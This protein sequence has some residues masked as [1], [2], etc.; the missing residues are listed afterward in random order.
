VEAVPGLVEEK[1]SEG[2][3]VEVDGKYM[4]P[5]TMK[6][7]G[8]SVEFH[9]VPVPGGNFKMGSSEDDEYFVEDEGPQA[10]IEVGPMWVS[11]YEATWAEYKLYMSMYQ[12][13]KS[14][15]GQGL[16]A[17]D[18]S[19]K[20]DAVTAP[21]ELY[22]PTYTFEFGDDPAYPAVTMTQYAAKQYTKWLSKLTGQQYRLP[23]E[24]EW[25]YACRG[26]TTTPFSFGEDDAEIDDYAWYYDNSDEYPHP[27]GQKKPNPFGLYDMHGNVMEWV[28]DGYTEDGHARLA[29]QDQPVPLVEAIHWAESFDNR[30]MRGGS[31]QD[32][33]E[34]L[35]SAARLA[36]QDEDWKE[37]DPNIPLSPWWFTDDPTRGLGF[38]VFRSYKPLDDATITKFWDIDNEDL[39]FDVDMRVDEGRGV[40]TPIDPSLAEDIAGRN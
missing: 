6:I 28:I 40:I 5:Y 19:N 9:M 27:V 16:R 11:K 23:T 13:F 2:P 7:P 14:L 20:V 22:D 29:E 12:L 31:F 21:T 24:A 26:G 32:D 33:P 37:E 36:S 3:F 39:Q 10:E 1:P 18:E 38:R 30:V 25:E 8:S 15:Q 4:V 34:S 17:L 35:R